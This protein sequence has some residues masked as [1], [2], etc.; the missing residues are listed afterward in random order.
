MLIWYCEHSRCLYGG[1]GRK[2]AFK[3]NLCVFIFV[4]FQSVYFCLGVGR[5]AGGNDLKD[6]I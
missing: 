3:G 5:F 6:T 4:A 1:A 2:N